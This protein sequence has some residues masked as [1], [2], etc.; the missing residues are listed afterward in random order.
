MQEWTNPQ[1]ASAVAKLM[2]RRTI[3]LTEPSPQRC[4]ACFGFCVRLVIAPGGERHEL[5]CIKC[6]GTGRQPPR[7]RSRR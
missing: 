7:R 3:P 4:R 1:Y 6:G 5:S 2:A